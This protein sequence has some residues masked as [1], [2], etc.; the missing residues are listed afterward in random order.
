MVKSMHKQAVQI[1]NLI[2]ENSKLNIKLLPDFP[3]NL[4]ILSAVPVI[5]RGIEID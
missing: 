4:T 5:L 1:Q 2:Q 3:G